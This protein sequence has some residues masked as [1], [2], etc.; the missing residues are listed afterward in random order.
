MLLRLTPTVPQKVL[1]VLLVDEIARLIPVT[2]CKFSEVMV[3]VQS[4]AS[5]TV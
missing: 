1:N 3:K 4:C 5:F 2:S